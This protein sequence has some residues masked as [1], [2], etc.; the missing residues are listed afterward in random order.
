LPA[1]GLP[2]QF[3]DFLDAINKNGAD[4]PQSGNCA[5]SG[6]RSRMAEFSRIPKVLG[7]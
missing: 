7:T 3:E 4:H 2:L 6:R 1:F 5:P